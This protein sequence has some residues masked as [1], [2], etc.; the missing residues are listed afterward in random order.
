MKKCA[1]FGGWFPICVIRHANNILK[2]E[3]LGAYYIVL[4][5]VRMNPQSVLS[6]SLSLSLSLLRLLSLLY[7][8][9]SISTGPPCCSNGVF[10]HRYSL[11]SPQVASRSLASK[12]SVHVQWV[13]LLSAEGVRGGE[14]H[15]RPSARNGDSVLPGDVHGR[16]D[17]SSSV[18]LFGPFLN[19]SV[20]SYRFRCSKALSP[21]WRDYT[22]SQQEE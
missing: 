12:K 18:T 1:S 19:V 8:H 7:A 5:H 17:H 2:P 6:L 4:G 10:E 9:L 20:H 21:Y 13:R 14:T 16:P 15:G 3:R 11:L 22:F